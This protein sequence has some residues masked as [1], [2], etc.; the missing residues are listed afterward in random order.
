[1]L[2]KKK[3]DHLFYAINGTSPEGPFTVSAGQYGVSKG[4]LYRQKPTSDEEAWLDNVANIIDALDSDNLHI[5]VYIHGYLAE[6]PWFA[7]L[8]GYTLHKEIFDQSAHDVNLVVSLQWDSGFN[9]TRNRNLAREK[10]R[11][12]RS[13]VV[14]LNERAKNMGKK[15]AFSFL[16]H[17]MGNIV[18]EGLVEGIKKEKELWHTRQVFCCAADLESDV[19]DGGL[20]H[21]PEIAVDIHV[22]FHAEDKTL[23]VANVMQKF[24]RLGIFGREDL[25]KA[26]N[27][28]S[29]DTTLISEDDMAVGSRFSHHRYFYG[30]KNVANYINRWLSK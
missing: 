7:S 29:L 12:F 2:V 11:Q 28:H 5:L 27:V 17:S 23:R 21:L 26:R 24:R 16:L 8:S 9:Y 22:L 18:F 4:F 15:P 30:S 1:M 14:R 19:F 13:V 3:P 6:N 25:N 20:R 10:G